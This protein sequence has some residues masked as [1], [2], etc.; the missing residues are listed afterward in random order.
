MTF[1]ACFDIV[2][3]QLGLIPRA[4]NKFVEIVAAAERYLIILTCKKI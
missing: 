2:F 1:W 3:A 4:M